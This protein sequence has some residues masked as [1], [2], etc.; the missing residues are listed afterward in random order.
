MN[1]D[2]SIRVLGTGGA[3]SESST[4]FLVNENILVDCGLDIIKNLI[5]GGL[6]DQIDYI[7]ITHLHMDHISG[8]ELFIYYLQCI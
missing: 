2:L 4:A 3:I 8:L 1:N 6:I 7:F 5:S